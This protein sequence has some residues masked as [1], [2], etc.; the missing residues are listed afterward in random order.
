MDHWLVVGCTLSDAGGVNMCS[1][2][3]TYERRQCLCRHG[4]NVCRQRLKGGTGQTILG[5]DEDGWNDN[6]CHRNKRPPT[7]TTND[8][9]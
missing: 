7:T 6:G 3:G 8:D 4:N 9:N 5:R 1:K 2:L